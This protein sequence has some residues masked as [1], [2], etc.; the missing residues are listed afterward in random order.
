MNF[1]SQCVGRQRD[2]M[3]LRVGVEALAADLTCSSWRLGFAF[4]GISSETTLR[5]RVRLQE[6]EGALGGGYPL[7]PFRRGT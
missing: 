5:F 3:V 7:G 4:E 2:G 1:K 6:E